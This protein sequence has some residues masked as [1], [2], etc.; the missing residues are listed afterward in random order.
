MSAESRF[1]PTNLGSGADTLTIQPRYFVA[2]A[3]RYRSQEQNL[4]LHKAL[5]NH[6]VT[7]SNPRYSKP[8]GPVRYA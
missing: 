7:K 6:L 4:V 2:T 1:E 5:L 3:F 8:F